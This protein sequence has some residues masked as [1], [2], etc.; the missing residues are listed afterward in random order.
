MKHCTV[1]AVTGYMVQWGAKEGAFFQ[2]EDG[3]P[4][5]RDRSVVVVRKALTG[6]GLDS[7]YMQAIVFGS[8]Q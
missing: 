7:P 3:H 6:I 1:V 8:G 4:L 5:T 2:F